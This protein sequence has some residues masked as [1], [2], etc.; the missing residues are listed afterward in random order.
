MTDSGG[1]D[2]AEGFLMKP[3]LSPTK[4]PRDFVEQLNDVIC[5]AA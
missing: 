1:F 3:E 2:S 4:G 5:Y